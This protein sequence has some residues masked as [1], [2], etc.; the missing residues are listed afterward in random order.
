M[1]VS[2]KAKH[3]TG[4]TKDQIKQAAFIGCQIHKRTSQGE[5]DNCPAKSQKFEK[6]KLFSSSDKKI[7]VENQNF[8]DSDRK[9][10]GKIGHFRA[11]EKKL[12]WQELR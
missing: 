10:L 1:F 9:K 8:L 2:K 5:G 3:R 6:N 7:F 12:Y 11:S 4:H